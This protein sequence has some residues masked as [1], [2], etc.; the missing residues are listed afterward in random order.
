MTAVSTLR[1]LAW[2]KFRTV[3]QFA[4][5]IVGLRIPLIANADSM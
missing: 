5:V 3:D 1:S 4:V 2:V